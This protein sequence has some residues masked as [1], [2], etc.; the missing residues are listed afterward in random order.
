MLAMGCAE[1][2]FS[3]ERDLYFDMG[4]I[5]ED[6]TEVFRDITNMWIESDMEGNAAERGKLQGKLEEIDKRVGELKAP[7][8]LKEDLKEWK[9]KHNEFTEFLVAYSEYSGE[10]GAAPDFT[11]LDRLSARIRNGFKEFER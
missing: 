5:N 3:L 11:D 10:I 2:I 8:H 6:V 1:D 7:K 4:E 9:K